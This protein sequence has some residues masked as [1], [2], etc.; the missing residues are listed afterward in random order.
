MLRLED[1]SHFATGS[2][3]YDDSLP[4]ETEGT[5]KI[6][7]RIIP[8][9]F[10]TEVIAQLDTGSP[11]LILEPEIAGVLGVDRGQGESYRL[12]TRFG[13]KSGRLERLPVTIVA[14]SGDSLEVDATVFLSPEWPA[15]L[16]F[17]GYTGVLERVRFAVDP[18]TN[19]FFFGPPG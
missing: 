14:D 10:A 2:A 15:G 5:A 7:I 13:E 1:G 4:D 19:R 11:W 12:S 9:T 17:V 3:R 6:F 18:A 16:N 8:G